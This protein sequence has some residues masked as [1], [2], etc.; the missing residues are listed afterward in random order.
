VRGA[1][2]KGR[3]YSSQPRGVNSATQTNNMK[4]GGDSA[5]HTDNILK[6]PVKGTR[7]LFGY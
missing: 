2:A 5:T 1:G 3:A 6:N 4:K 7:N